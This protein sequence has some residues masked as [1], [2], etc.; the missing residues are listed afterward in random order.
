MQ[1]QGR[2]LSEGMQGEDVALLHGELSRLRTAGLL[3]VKFDP[4]EV[5]GQ[6][7]GTTTGEA[8]RTFQNRY[9]LEVTAIVDE[10][11]VER[12]NAEVDVLRQY[13]IDGHVMSRS[14][15]GVDRLRV[16]IVDNGGQGQILIRARETFVDE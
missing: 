13:Q 5:A 16:E 1:L 14:R 11:T 3:D 10:T 6:L 12:I 2:N 9:G 7:F 8:V 15:A 4:E